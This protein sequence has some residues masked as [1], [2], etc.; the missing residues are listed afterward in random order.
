MGLGYLIVDRGELAEPDAIR[1]TRTVDRPV[2]S[3]FKSRD[4]TADQVRTSLYTE[5]LLVGYRLH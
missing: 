3:Q 2:P 4:L 5:P 1:V